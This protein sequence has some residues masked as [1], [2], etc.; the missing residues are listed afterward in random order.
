MKKWGSNLLLIA[1][2]SLITPGLPLLANEAPETV[3]LLSEL[4][5]FHT[6]IRTDT[7]ELGTQLQY[8]DYREVTPNS[9]TVTKKDFI[10][11]VFFGYFLKN[12]PIFLNLQVAYQS[13]DVIG[14]SLLQLQT[15]GGYCLFRNSSHELGIYAGID[16]RNTQQNFAEKSPQNLP[17]SSY[18]RTWFSLLAPL[19]LKWNLFVND[20]FHLGL[21]ASL[22][23]PLGTRLAVRFPPRKTGFSWKMQAPVTYWMDSSFG[24][25][26]NPFVESIAY[27]EPASQTYQFGSQVKA[28]LRF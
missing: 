5:R 9:D 23:I 12:K 18:D 4:E 6:K 10:P 28:A 22:G 25:T 27:S 2:I 1:G 17:Q 3:T 7:L 15:A 26:F 16:L 20:R 13:S 19:G 21:D 24:I 8:F 14:F 11:G